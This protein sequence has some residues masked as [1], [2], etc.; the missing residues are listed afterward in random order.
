M[1]TT[2]FSEMSSNNVG[3]QRRSVVSNVSSLGMSGVISED[4]RNDNRLNCEGEIL[5]KEF[6]KDDTFLVINIDVHI[7]H[8]YTCC[9]EASR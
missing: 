6:I 3:V 2:S 8:A 1:T 5:R 4:G 9:P 7:L